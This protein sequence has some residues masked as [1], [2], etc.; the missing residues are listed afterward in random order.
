M[1]PVAAVFV[2]GFAIVSTLLQAGEI[3]DPIFAVLA[4]L[5]VAGAAG[6]LVWAARP[7][8]APFE[9]GMT[10]SIVGLALLGHLFEQ[11]SMWGRN[12]LIQDDFGQICIG[13]LLLALAP[14]RPWREILI[15]GA[16]ASVVVGVLAVAQAQ[17]LDVVVPPAIYAIVAMTELLAPT[18][19]GAAYSRQLVRS[20]RI[21]QVDARRG[22]VR[23]TG[24][25]RNRI[26]Q[27]VVERR[28]AT[29]NSN[30]LP[31]LA[32]VLERGTVTPADVKRARGLAS[33]VRG[34][35]VAEVEHTWLDDLVARE[36]AALTA[37]GL[38]P[39]LVVGDPDRRATG[40]D[41]AQRAATA[42]LIVALCGLRSFDPCSLVVQITGPA[43]GSH[44][45]SPSG[46]APHR[47]T[48]TAPGVDT[49]TVQAGVGP[50][51]RS[52]RTLLRPYLAVL[53]VTFVNVRVRNR[54]PVLTVEF[55]AE[56]PTVRAWNG[57]S[58]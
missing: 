23:R 43:P 26:A 39:L 22:V 52:R 46:L 6:A 13:L 31:F 40:F 12:A 41:A 30:V 29:Q 53:R 1:A 8:Q 9:R 21:W 57:D 45:G 56:H 34:V 38:S 49:V 25:G 3:R 11:A 37:R 58:R 32:E 18:F 4:L 33:Q 51:T 47:A 54:H 36:S 2:V 28:L 24:E 10:V 17:W 50:S 55:D 44:S 5:A 14:F 16:A 15:A 20:I 35:L 27:S 19:A 7:E 48:D 42:S